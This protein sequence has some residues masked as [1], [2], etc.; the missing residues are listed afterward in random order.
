[1][2]NMGRKFSSKVALFAALAVLQSPSMA[3]DAARS[4]NAV[5]TT[6]STHR[7]RPNWVGGVLGCIGIMTVVKRNRRFLI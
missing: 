6:R 3:A 2:L 4:D 7:L 1:M 5:T